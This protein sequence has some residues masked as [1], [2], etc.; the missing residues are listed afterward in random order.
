MD[1]KALAAWSVAQKYKKSTTSTRLS[2]I[3]AIEKVYGDLE[4]LYAQDGL[5]GLLKELAYSSKDKAA[6]RP[7]PSKLPL[8]G[9]TYRDLSHLRATVNYYRRF[10]T[11]AARQTKVT[12]MPD[13][14]A[15]E[16]AVAEYLDLGPLEF[17]DRYSQ[18][19]DE[20][21]VHLLKDSQTQRPCRWPSISTAR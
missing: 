12:A 2:D 1:E 18:T 16:A 10:K 14:A 11:G 4:D 6:N 13:L 15:I 3:R 21:S 17:M 20:V 19:W 9:D 8:W 5:E 7:N